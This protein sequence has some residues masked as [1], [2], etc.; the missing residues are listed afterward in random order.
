MTSRVGWADKKR[1]H[2]WVI[3]DRASASCSPSSFSRGV[4]RVRPSMQMVAGP[5]T[6]AALDQAALL[7]GNAS[8][9]R[10]PYIPREARGR[11]GEG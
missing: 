5:L 6:S 1:I 3:L 7:T 2:L 4:S 11:A 10:H 9:A 8:I